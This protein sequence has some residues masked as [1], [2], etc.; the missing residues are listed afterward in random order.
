MTTIRKIVTSKVDGNSADTNDTNEIRPFGEIAVYLN[1][2]ANPDK[3][4]LMMFDGIRTHMKSMVLAPGRLYGSDADSGDGNNRDTIK[5]IP[6]A[7][8]SD[9]TG[10][11]QYL[12]IDPTGGEPGHIHIRAGGTQDSSSADLYLGGELTCVRV[13]D[14]SD[15]VT[16]RTTQSGDP[17]ITKEWQFSPDGNLYL[18][19]TDGNYTIGESEPGL[20][21]SSS[22][23]VA[24]LTN[25]MASVSETKDLIFDN[26]GKLRLNGAEVDATSPRAQVGSIVNIPLNAAGDTVDYTGGASLIEVPINEDTDLV[27][28]GWIITFNGGARRT[29]SGKID[30]GGYYAITFNEANPGGTLYPLT[31]ESADFVASATG[32]IK[33]TPDPYI[34]S[35]KSWTF[36]E[37]GDLTLPL[38]GDILDSNGASVLGGGIATGVSRSDDNLIIRLTDPQDDGLE[39]RSLVVDSNDMDVVSTV[40]GSNGFIIRTN[41]NVSQKQWQ[42][43]N[44]GGLTFPDGTTQTSAVSVVQGVFTFEMDENNTTATISSITGNLLIV[45]TAPGYVGSDTH[46]VTLPT[47]AG[48]QR[49]VISNITTLCDFVVDQSPLGVSTITPGARAEFI[50]DDTVDQVWIPLYGVV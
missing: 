29:V 43:D 21:L 36:S 47:G 26:D 39:L 24:F 45:T 4:T 7:G 20:V 8:L 48:G 35:P 34:E 33:L 25:S 13:S 30:G 6:D 40:L 11:D 19:T 37:T 23:G 28:A 49:L 46:T 16:I 2:E 38:G 17:A 10:N 32:M 14:T 9:F 41:S 22:Q 44:D 3:L 27:Q 50:Y 31:V 5:L 1:T 42:F 12:I 15:I 18:P